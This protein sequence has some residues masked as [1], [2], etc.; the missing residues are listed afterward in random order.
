MGKMVAPIAGGKAFIWEG[1]GSVANNNITTPI[2]PLCWGEDR[3]FNLLCWIEKE[4][5]MHNHQN[6]SGSSTILQYPHLNAAIFINA[7]K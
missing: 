2:K 3:C 7:L 1:F 4:G 6:E 5:E